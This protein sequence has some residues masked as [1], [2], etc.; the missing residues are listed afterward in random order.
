[1]ACRTLSTK[2]PR[3]VVALMVLVGAC[4][5]VVLGASSPA[6]AAARV[7]VANQNG[8][9]VADPDYA[10]TLTLHG[11][12]FQSIKG[13]YGG[14]YVLFGT[15]HSGWRPSKG[16]QTGRD[17]FYVPD[18]EAKNNHGF[19]KFVT[20]PGSDTAAAANGGT[21]HANGTWST[22]LVVPGATFQA[23]DRNG[24]A[25]TIN[26]LKVT[27]G[28]ITIGAH[29]LAN[30]HNESFT[31]VRFASLSSSDD[32][33][34]ST[35]SAQ[36]EATTSADAGDETETGSGTASQTTDP[37][38]GT[39]TTAT[40]PR[41]KVDRSTAVLGRVMSFSGV[42]F[43]PGEQV[44]ASFDDGLAAVGPL[45]AGPDG[46]IA[47]VLQLPADLEAGTHTLKL[48]GA[49]SGARP[50]VNFA[51]T[52][53]TDEAVTATAG[54]S[55]QRHWPAYAFAA[56]GVAVLVAALLFALVA[57]RRRRRRHAVMKGVT[58]AA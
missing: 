6:A 26:C 47:G 14:I 34:T 36:P 17:Y 37:G 52:A 44:V 4:A 41:A 15:V 32:E 29:G 22:T 7:S 12:G 55:E 53:P 28:I 16:G 39:T 11:S 33:A 54:T 31:P 57:A 45:T 40:K 24:K 46:E 8:E 10:T 19:E 1:M 27:C 43:T 20:F 2:I 56:G 21:L 23:V 5:T 9:A 58:H 38:A 3:I 51:V 25:T 49:A 50:H 42:G 18:T 48:T 35:S 30:A 13:G